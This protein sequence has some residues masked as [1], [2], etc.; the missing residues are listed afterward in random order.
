MNKTILEKVKEVTGKAETKYVSFFND[1]TV[2]ED[3]SRMD[4]RM[5]EANGPYEGRLILEEIVEGAK[6]Y[7]NFV[8]FDSIDMPLLLGLV[9]YKNDIDDANQKKETAK[10][11]KG[12]VRYYTGEFEALLDG[13]K[14]NKPGEYYP[15]IQGFV[16]YD[17]LMKEIKKS[18]L[19]YTGP[20]T[21]EEFEEQ[22]LVGEPFDI[23]VSA[24]LVEKE[25]TK[26]DSKIKRK[27][28]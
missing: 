4:K 7:N 27:K 11:I 24:N 26:T 14:N 3:N 8:D 5:Q 28:K 21:F 20:E 15:S 16:K 17:N 9:Y 22:I 2:E 12:I 18:G 1:G 13:K 10:P 6:L 23:K 19:D 25:N